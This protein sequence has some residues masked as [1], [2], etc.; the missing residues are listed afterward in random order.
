MTRFLK[1]LRKWT[2]PCFS[3]S[4]LTP[5]WTRNYKVSGEIQEFE[6]FFTFYHFLDV[7]DM[8][9]TT[10]FIKVLRKWI[11]SCFS[12]SVPAPIWTRNYKVSG[13]I[14]KSVKVFTF[15][16]FPDA[17]DMDHTT[18]FIRVLRKLIFSCFPVP[19]PASIWTRNCSVS[20]GILKTVKFFILSLFGCS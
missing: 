11:F 9:Y 15:Y 10:R 7:P 20:G 1:V 8:D 16:N 3:V 4:V 14:L 17:L 2:F 12:V 13:E 18:R 19:V 5:I 6:K